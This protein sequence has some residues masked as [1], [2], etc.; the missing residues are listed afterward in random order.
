MDTAD[1]A[2]LTAKKDT[3]NA[4]PDA[5]RLTFL[6]EQ[7]YNDDWH[8]YYSACDLHLV[9]FGEKPSVFD[10][11]LETATTQFKP[12]IQNVVTPLSTLGITCARKTSFKSKRKQVLKSL[13]IIS[14]YSR[15]NDRQVIQ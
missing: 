3:L 10:L 4:N 12:Y 11:P 7:L 1:I 6:F 13:R 5:H 8:D 14:R 9:S 15:Y 2:S